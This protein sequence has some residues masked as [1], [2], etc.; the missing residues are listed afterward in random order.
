MA[1]EY[2][3]LSLLWLQVN[4]AELGKVD[5]DNASDENIH[6]LM[7]LGQRLIDK[8]IKNGILYKIC[9]DLLLTI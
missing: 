3:A 9:V 7:L 5:M 4:L 8:N 2:E 1:V 6:E